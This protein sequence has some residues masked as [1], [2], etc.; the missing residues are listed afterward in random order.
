MISMGYSDVTRYGVAY[1]LAASPYRYTWG[2]RTFHFSTAAHRERFKERL[3][4]RREWL[5]DSLSRRFKVQVR[6]D[7]LAVLQ[8]YM[9]TETRGFYVT[10]DDGEGRVIDTPDKVAVTVE[11]Q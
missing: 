7:D 11:V 8:L 4:I 10:T 2:L 6:A 9:K 3:T 5:N 1:N